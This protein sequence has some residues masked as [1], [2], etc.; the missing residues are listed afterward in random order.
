M[1]PVMMRWLS[2]S[3]NSAEL[4][5]IVFGC[6]CSPTRFCLAHF[7]ASQQDQIQ[8]PGLIHFAKIDVLRV[9]A[10]NKAEDVPNPD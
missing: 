7:A 5:A 1:M 4:E 10:N 9:P 2:V 3:R 8:E 6:R